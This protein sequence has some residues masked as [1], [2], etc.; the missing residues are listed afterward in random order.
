[1]YM[2]VQ[3]MRIAWYLVMFIIIWLHYRMYTEN[4]GILEY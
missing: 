3:E 4:W 2:Y 1:M